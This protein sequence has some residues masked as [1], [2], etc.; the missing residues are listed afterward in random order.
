MISCCSTKTFHIA[1]IVF[2]HDETDT[3]R[4]QERYNK[5][6]IFRF[7]CLTVVS[8]LT[9]Y[10]SSYLHILVIPVTII[11]NIVL[12]K[13]PGFWDMTAFRLFYGTNRHGGLPKK[14]RTF[15]NASTK[16][17][18][19]TRVTQIFASAIRGVF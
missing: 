6:Y 19:L 17:C 10:V 13:I 3:R 8:H 1:T 4:V 18:N 5:S 15:I 9:E 7:C 14:T 11:D 16:S 12:Y 2:V